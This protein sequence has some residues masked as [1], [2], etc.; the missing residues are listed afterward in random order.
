MSDELKPIDLEPGALAAPP[1]LL[2]FSGYS[3]DIACWN[4]F[5]GSGK[6]LRAD[7]HDDCA[8]GVARVW[9]VTWRGASVDVVAIYSPGRSGTWSIGLCQTEED[10]DLPAWAR[11]PRIE[12]VGYSVEFSLEVGADVEVVL[13]AP[14]PERE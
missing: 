1:A 14:G 7:E 5:D 3:D 8:R 6:E 9:R 11:R 10:V 2:K 13:S 4:L 12:G